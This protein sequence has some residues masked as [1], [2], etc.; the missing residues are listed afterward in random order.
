MPCE[1]CG[2]AIP[3]EARACPVCGFEV[4]EEVRDLDTDSSTYPAFTGYLPLYTPL[5]DGAPGNAPAFWLPMPMNL[6]T[7]AEPVYSD[8]IPRERLPTEP[9]SRLP[10]GTS[11]RIPAIKKP[12]KPQTNHRIH[13][14]A[15]FF[16]LLLAALL[17][18]AYALAVLVGGANSATGLQLTGV[19]AYV[20]ASVLAGIGVL[21]S[22]LSRWSARRRRR[23][24]L[25]PQLPSES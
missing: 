11:P 3:A 13:W 15:M 7:A 17:V 22:G 25:A 12:P 2:S 10:D 24:D 20:L 16:G 23:N 4:A 18:T 21:A 19:T 14:L 5:P 8:G 1:R 9:L 6:G